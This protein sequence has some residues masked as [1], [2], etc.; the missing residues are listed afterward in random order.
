MMGFDPLNYH[1]LTNR[2]TTAI[3]PGDLL[4]FIAACGHAPAI[5]DLA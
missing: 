3:A 4:R 1:P 5:V 2:A